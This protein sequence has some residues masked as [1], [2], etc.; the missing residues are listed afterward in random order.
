MLL[1]DWVSVKTNVYGWIRWRWWWIA[2]WLELSPQMVVKEMKEEGCDILSP[3]RLPKKY[4]RCS[5]KRRGKSF[6]LVNNLV[7]RKKFNRHTH[8]KPET[9]KAIEIGFKEVCGV[10]ISS[11]LFDPLQFLLEKHGAI[12]CFPNKHR[13]FRLSFRD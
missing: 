10:L 5:Q 1:I 9:F 6:C 11:A 7:K 12:K 3:P 13:I 2:S 4:V 8:P